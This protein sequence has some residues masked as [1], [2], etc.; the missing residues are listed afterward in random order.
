MKPILDQYPQVIKIAEDAYKSSNVEIKYIPIRGGTDGATLSY[1]G[2]PCPNLFT[3]GGNFHSKKEFLSVYGLEK[4]VE[5][6]TNI[7][8]IIAS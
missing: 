8:K 4:A 7:V 2:L 1:K 6:L 3:G 5:V